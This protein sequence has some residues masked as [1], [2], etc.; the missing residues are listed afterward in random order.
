VA[1]GL[2]ALGVQGRLWS[3]SRTPAPPDELEQTEVPPERRPAFFEEAALLRYNRTLIRRVNADLR[4]FAPAAVYQRHDAFHLSGLALAR[5]WKVPLVLEVN[6]SEVWARQAWSR[7][8]LKRL[9]VWMERIA[10]RQA[11]RLVL[12]SEE[13]VPTVTALGGSPER[14]VV[15]PNGVEVERFDPGSRGEPV[16]R[17]S[18]WPADAIVCGFLGTFARWHGVLFLAEEAPRLAAADPRLRFLL[19][20][21]GDLRP[22]VEAAFRDAGLGDRARFPGIVPRE[23]VPEH[24]AACDL[25]LS[26]HLPF[27]DGTAFFGSPT[28]LFEYMAAG[29]AIVASRLGPIARLVED[30]E[31]GVLF[32]PGEG[33]PFR[34]AVLRLAGD[35]A[36]RAR[37]GRNARH[38]AEA[39][40]TWTANVRRSLEGL[41]PLPPAASGGPLYGS[42]ASH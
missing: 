22:A 2:R 8:F 19:L 9:A 5:R 39:R 31:T 15:N 11:D 20:G 16:R 27:E 36:E 38:R 41:V 37:L 23:R 32:P 7:L 14:I 25:L 1:A 6:A 29:R 33:R 34:E 24:L 18:G 30:G 35:A 13:L 28:K 4:G 21:D 42:R 17:D 10:F 12:I 3:P 26:P 40:Y